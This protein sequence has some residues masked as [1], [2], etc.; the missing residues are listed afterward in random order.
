MTIK[1]TATTTGTFVA[2]IAVIEKTMTYSSTNYTNVFKK[3][4]P[5]Y[6]GNTFTLTNVGDSVTITKTW[7]YTNVQSTANLAAVGYIQNTS[8]KTVPQSAMSVLGA[9][10]LP[11]VAGFAAATTTSCTGSIQFT[12]ASSNTPTTWAWTFGDG[13]TST[14]QNPSHTYAASG[15]YSVSLKATNAYGNN[16]TTKTSYITINLPA[17]PSVTSG[18]TTQG[19]SVTLSATGSGTLN[20]YD[21]ATAGNLVN[22]GLTYTINPLTTNKTFYVENDVSSSAQSVGM[23]AKGATG[24]YYTST[25]RQGEVFDALSDITLNSVTVYANTTANRTIFLKNSS[26]TVIDSIVETNLPSGTQTVT[27]NWSIPAGTGY[28]LGCSSNNSLWR[29]TAG[30]SYPYTAT[31]LISITGNT[32]GSTYPAYYYYF[33][34]WQVSGAPCKSARVPVYAT[35]ST[36]INENSSQ[37]NFNLFPNPNT[38]E[39]T[40]NINSLQNQN[41]TVNVVDINGKIVYSDILN[42]KGELNKTF[43]FTDYSKGIYFMRIIS[44]KEVYNK[45]IIIQ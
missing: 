16:T 24:G 15:T 32:A 10:N 20:W 3:F 18:S 28:T 38:G 34:N 9:S 1:R 29:E 35:I 13:G 7:T 11:P 27:L 42:I 2:K 33:Y 12:D 5:D 17:S 22:T 30:A 43:D 6:N 8:D 25:A 45:K 21:A 44:D 39:F 36:G 19:G 40:L 37:I 41:V 4:L 31:G 23:T 26:G 14:I